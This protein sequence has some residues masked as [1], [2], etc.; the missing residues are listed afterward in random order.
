MSAANDVWC[1]D[2]KGW[3]RT[4]EGRRCDPFTLTDAH[5]RY[6]LRCQVTGGCVMP[7][8]TWATFIRSDAGSARVTAR[9]EQAWGFDGDR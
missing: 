1:T 9:G 4:G 8:S 5:S 3:F 7:T 6:L 2:F